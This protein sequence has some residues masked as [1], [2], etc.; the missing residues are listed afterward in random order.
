MDR[1]L[2]FLIT[3]GLA[4]I[5]NLLFRWFLN[6]FIVFEIAVL[7]SYI[8]AMLLAFYL[9][10]IFVFEATDTS[11]IVQLFRFILVNIV[12]LLIVW[13]VSVA[14]YRVIFPYLDFHWYAKS[15]SHLI[16]VCSPV[17]VS[18]ILH[19]KYTFAKSRLL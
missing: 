5:F 19:K 18:Y 14:L 8:C 4:A 13:S 2:K 12:S 3:G 15:I 16:G 17:F 7:A 10:K 1:F 9:T 11:L 6:G